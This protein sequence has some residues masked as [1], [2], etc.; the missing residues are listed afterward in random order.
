MTVSRTVQAEARKLKGL[1][2]MELRWKKLAPENWKN[3]GHPGRWE[4]HLETT[5]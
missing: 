5:S 3:T 2:A 1:Q 4:P